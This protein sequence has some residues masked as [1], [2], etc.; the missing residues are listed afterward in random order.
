A[1]ACARQSGVL[2]PL[3]PGGDPFSLGV[4]SGEPAPD[5]FV[6]WTRLAPDP[7][8]KDPG[9]PGGMSGGDLG[10]GYEIARD[11][12]MRD[13]VQRGSATAEAAFAHSVH[14]EVTGLEPGRP[15]W[16]RFTSGAAQSPIGRALT[17]PA[18]GAPLAKLRFAC[19]SC[20]N[21]E[22]GY[23]ASY[24]HLAAENPDL[25]LFLGDYI[26]EYIETKRPTV[27]KHSDDVEPTTLPGYRNRY[28]Q[29]R[30]DSDL[31]NLHGSVSALVTWDDHEVQN[32][33]ADRWSQDFDDPEH[34]LQRR[35]AAYQAFYEHM[36]LRPSRVRPRSGSLDLYGRFGFGDLLEFS[37]LDGRQYRS[38]EACYAKPDHGGGHVETDASCPELRDPHRN[39]LGPAQESWLAA[40]LSKSRAR[41]NVIAQDVLMAQLR[42]RLP[43]GK[44]GFWTDDW[45]G[46]P[47]S[48]RKLLQ[49]IHDQ[50]VQNALVLSGDIHSF[51]ANDLK[52]DFDDPRSPTVASELVGT[53]I[54]SY[55]L[56]YDRF[57]GYLADNPHVRFFDSRWRGYMVSD[58][59]PERVTTRFQ[60]ISNPQD[61]NAALSTLATFVVEDGKPGPVRG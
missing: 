38:R 45:N 50:R 36:P 49:T 9:S 22:A 27:R 47:V 18:P 26:Y 13:V 33:Y 2:G 30:L 39:Y 60:A 59:T 31:Q 54:T 55:G 41:W 57:A 24:R 16:Y 10:L 14:L 8:S 51:W 25:V 40:S 53:S 29:Y 15:Y 6:L 21:Y 61:P 48:R 44:I 5:G 4:A 35:A 32:D 7:L 1:P 19:A 56:P 46:Y 58:V 52:L 11:E 20:S 42:E 23:F 12:G 28:A 37:V 17:A 43:D 34:F 3:W